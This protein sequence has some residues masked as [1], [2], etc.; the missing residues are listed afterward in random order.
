MIGTCCAQLATSWNRRSSVP[1]SSYRDTAASCEGFA[2]PPAQP[3]AWEEWRFAIPSPF[4]GIVRSPLGTR[5]SVRTIIHRQLPAARPSRG[6]KCPIGP[7]SRYPNCVVA[8][9]LFHVKQKR[10]VSDSRLTHERRVE[11]F[12]LARVSLPSPNAR[13][14]RTA[15]RRTPGTRKGSQVRTRPVGAA[16]CCSTENRAPVACQ[17]VRM[18]RSSAGCSQQGRSGSCPRSGESSSPERPN[19]PPPARFPLGRSTPRVG[20]ARRRSDHGVA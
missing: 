10:T 8:R 7:C 5:R 6:G 9:G 20:S 15:W 12:S 14:T 3:P 4:A 13:Q 11:R 16:G 17:A 2:T 1:A 19:G 18:A